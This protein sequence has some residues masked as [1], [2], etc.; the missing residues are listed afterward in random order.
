MAEP[1]DVD[2]ESLTPDEFAHLV[3]EHD[4]DTLR[5]TFRAVGT[6][7]ALDRIFAIM[8]ERYLPQKAGDIDATVQWRISD[9]GQEHPYVVHL[10]PESCATEA[11]ET[12]NPDTTLKI[13]LARFARVAAGQAN[14]VRLLLTRK[15]KASGDIGLAKKLPTLF[16][17]PSV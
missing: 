6:G 7:R 12:S 17:I 3:S 13:D 11:G 15:L 9:D 2:V 4:D 1:V 5:A 16:D 14:G 10:A 8:Q